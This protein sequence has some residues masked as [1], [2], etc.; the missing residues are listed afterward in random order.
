MN[1]ETASILFYYP[2]CIVITCR[3]PQDRDEKEFKMVIDYLRRGILA[4]I[5]NYYW[6]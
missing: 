6:Q 4:R 1:Y 5:L 2:D 3:T